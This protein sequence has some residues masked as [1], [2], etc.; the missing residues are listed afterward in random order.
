MSCP[1]FTSDCFSGTL[2][3]F[4]LDEG[5]SAGSSTLLNKFTLGHV[6]ILSE[7]IGQSLFI[8]VETK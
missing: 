1:I 3:I 4:I 7:D 8:D 6:A 5:D 2:M